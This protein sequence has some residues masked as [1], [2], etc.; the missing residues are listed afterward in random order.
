MNGPSVASGRLCVLQVPVLQ[1]VPVPEARDLVCVALG[2]LEIREVRYVP[3]SSPSL[4]ACA[5]AA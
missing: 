2:S 5:A 3:P 1:I 4:P